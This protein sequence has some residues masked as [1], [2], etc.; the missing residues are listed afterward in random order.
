MPGKGRFQAT[1]KLGDVIS[2]S[3]KIAVS[4]IRV[5]AFALGITPQDTDI[6]LGES[7]DKDLHLHMP[8]GGTGKDGPSA[9]IAILSA[10]ISTLTRVPIN[11]D[12]GE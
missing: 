6:L 2:E 12:L 3:V 11:P 1:G 4:Y 9:G 10:M 8:D 5:N 7:S